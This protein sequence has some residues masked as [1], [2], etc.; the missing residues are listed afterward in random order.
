MLEVGT[1][2]MGRLEALPSQC[3]LAGVAY[4]GKV[5]GRAWHLARPM[6]YAWCLMLNVKCSILSSQ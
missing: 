2:F 6:F 4:G 3:R 1:F 5:L